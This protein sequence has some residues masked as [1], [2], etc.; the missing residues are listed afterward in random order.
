MWVSQVGSSWCHSRPPSGAVDPE[1][2]PVL[3][4]RRR[5]G[6]PEDPARPVRVA[7]QRA[8]G[9]VEPPPGNHRPDIGR[10]GLRLH[11]GHR[12]QQVICVAADV[13]EDRRRTRSGGIE[14][15]VVGILEIGA[16]REL[17]LEVLDLAEP[18]V[19]DLAVRDHRPRLAHHGIGGIVVGGAEDEPARL[20]PGDEVP[21]IVQVGGERLVADDVPPRIEPAA[22]E[23]VVAVVRGHDRDHV[24]PVR[25]RRLRREHLVDV[26]VGPLRRPAERPPRGAR[27]L[28]VRGQH[29]AHHLV[30]VVEARRGAVDLADDASGAASEH[31]E[32]QSPAKLLDD[33]ICGH[34]ALH[35]PTSPPGDR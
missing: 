15:P 28:R 18:E 5:L 21:G 34:G 10:D 26:A 19:P 22:G 33:G 24:H 3:G 27:P 6:D 35:L 17:R 1:L 12:V 32:T 4:A 9:I 29:P 8:G 13:P 7:E 20:H 31:P 2:E 23:P 14:A 25:P 16:H 30:A 11:S